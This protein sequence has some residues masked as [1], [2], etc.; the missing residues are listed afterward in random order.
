MIEV[1]IYIFSIAMQ[2]AGAVILI[3]KYW[4]G[5]SKKQLEEIQTKRTYVEG[6]ILYLG[7]SE[8]NDQEFIEELWINRLAFIFL[9]IGYL[10]GV[11]GDISNSNKW[12]TLLMIVLLTIVIVFAGKCFARKK[13]KPY[14]KMD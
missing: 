7:I 4:T 11:W 3:L 5:S 13:G 14:Q 8:P 10:S 2:L 12:L 1:L 9:A 6:E